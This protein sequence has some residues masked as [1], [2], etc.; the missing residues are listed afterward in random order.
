MVRHW[1]SL[2]AVLA[3][4]VVVIAADASPGALRDRRQNRRARRNGNATVT[5]VSS[6]GPAL[7]GPYYMEP[8]GQL[9][10]AMGRA[11]PGYVDEGL[12]A[13]NQTLERGANYP[14]EMVGSAQGARPVRLEVRVP[15]NAEV[16]I[17]GE[18]T[19]TKGPVRQFVSP[20]IQP[21]QSPYSYKIEAK[22]TDNGQ[23]RTETR[24]VE[25]RPGQVV[26]LDLT[27]RSEE[28]QQ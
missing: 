14:P 19:V 18:K 9:V 17:D 5:Y 21:R 24:T 11:V 27:R 7:S 16:L 1:F 25:V 4:A 13:A 3:V 28:K 26:R 10:D 23:E 12:F 20:P 2:T 22:W 6:T 8:S 15:A